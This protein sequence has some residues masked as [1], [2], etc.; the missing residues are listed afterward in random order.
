MVRADDALLAD[1]AAQVD[2]NLVTA[3]ACVSAG[4]VKSDEEQVRGG[5]AVKAA[6]ETMKGTGWRLHCTGQSE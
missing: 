4:E 3:L 5:S 2:Q 6:T 1:A